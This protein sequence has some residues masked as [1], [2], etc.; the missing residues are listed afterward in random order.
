VSNVGPST[1]L[2]V[3]LT[4]QVPNGTKY[5]G[6][7]STQGTC[8]HPASGATSG[9]ITCSFGS[10]AT[11]SPAVGTVT[12]K[13]TLSGKGGSIVNVAQAYSTGGSSTPDPNLANNVAS[14]STTISKK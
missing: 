6:L 1:A 7:T 13:I 5:V 12:L 11:G 8:S 4:A 9:T 2:N 14:Y 3:V 10:L